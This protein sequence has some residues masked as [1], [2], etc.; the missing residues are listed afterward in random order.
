MIDDSTLE[1]FVFGP[2]IVKMKVGVCCT[3]MRRLIGRRF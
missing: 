3:I 1:F 2:N